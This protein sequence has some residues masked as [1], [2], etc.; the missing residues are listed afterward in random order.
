[1]SRTIYYLPLDHTTN[2][3]RVQQIQFS[4]VNIN[5]RANSPITKL[6]NKNTYIYRHQNT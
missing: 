3:T 1:M 4:V 2:Q 6:E 5:I